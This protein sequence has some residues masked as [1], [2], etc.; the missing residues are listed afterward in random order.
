MDDHETGTSDRILDAA[1]RLM[2]AKGFKSVTIKDIAAASDVSEMTVFRH[3]KTKKGVLE[4]AVQKY[5]YTPGLK[6]IVEQNVVY[7]L[8]HDLKLI[9]ASYLDLMEVNR[10]I[11]LIAVQERATMPELIGLIADNTKRLHGVLTDYFLT[12]QERGKMAV[13]DASK[14]AMMFLTMYYGYFSSRA[15]W[16][17]QFISDTQEEF[18]ATSVSTFCEGLAT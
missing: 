1:L 7:D 12:M 15:L 3:Y 6:I 5:S 11:F 13:T 14:Q 16:D 8:N 9:A 2:Q 17:T 18:I 4:A 10:G